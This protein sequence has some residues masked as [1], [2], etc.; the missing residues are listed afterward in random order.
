VE[1]SSNQMA[2]SPTKIMAAMVALHAIRSSRRRR[3]RRALVLSG[4]LLSSVGLYRGH[5]VSCRALNSRGAGR[6]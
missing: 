1:T 6:P 3:T 4:A 2:A 5:F